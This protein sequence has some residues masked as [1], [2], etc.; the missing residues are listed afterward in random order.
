MGVNTEHHFLINHGI[1]QT[2]IHSLFTSLKTDRDG[3]FKTDAHQ[4]TERQMF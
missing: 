2:I 3:N 1:T 4:S